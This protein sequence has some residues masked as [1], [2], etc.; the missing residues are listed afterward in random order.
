MGKI[1]IRKDEDIQEA[2]KKIGVNWRSVKSLNAKRYLGKMKLKYDPLSYQ[3][4]IRKEWDNSG[5]PN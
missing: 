3:R 1:V 2:R 5:H 4:Q